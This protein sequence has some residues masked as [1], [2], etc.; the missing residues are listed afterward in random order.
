MT[1]PVI[2][3]YA[4]GIP[5]RIEVTHYSAAERDTYW[6]PGAPEEVEIAV[7]DRR[8]RPAPW[9]ERKLDEDDWEHLEE[10]A[11][12]ACRKAFRN[13]SRNARRNAVPDYD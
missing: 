11:I 12:M 4:C 2:D 10:E 7:L 9:L 13:A 8:G 1:Y 3:A 6:E 5:C